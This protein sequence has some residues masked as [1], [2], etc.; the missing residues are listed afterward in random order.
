MQLSL[1]ALLCL[2]VSGTDARRELS[3]ME[4]GSRQ[5][6]IKG[7]GADDIRWY[8]LSLANGVPSLEIRG[9]KQDNVAAAKARV[10]LALDA[11]SESGAGERLGLAGSEAYWGPIRIDKQSEQ[12]S[13]RIVLRSTMTRPEKDVAGNF[14]VM[15]LQALVDRDSDDFVLRPMIQNFPYDYAKGKG[16][17]SLEQSVDATTAAK[18]RLSIGSDGLVGIGSFG[19]LAVDTDSVYEDGNPGTIK[20]PRPSSKDAAAKSINI[21]FATTRPKNATFT[22]RLIFN[23]QAMQLDLSEK[24]KEGDSG[25]IKGATANGAASGYIQGSSALLGLSVAMLAGALALVY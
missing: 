5:V 10:R 9:G 15:E 16:I 21:Q 13:G 4:Q 24:E 2:L 3:I 20:A 25:K 6:V 22:E 18:A 11:V 12:D 14:F 23:P 1:T 8:T 7:K 19:S 17:L